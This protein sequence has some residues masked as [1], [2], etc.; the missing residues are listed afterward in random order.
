MFHVNILSLLIIVDTKSGT[1]KKNKKELLIHKFKLELIN[2]ING[3]INRF[4][5]V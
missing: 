1:E 5:M 4:L 2:I 3:M